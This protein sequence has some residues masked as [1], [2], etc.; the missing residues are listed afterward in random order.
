MPELR[1]DPIGDHWVIL[2]PGRAQRSS[3]F[4]S[5]NAAVRSEE[6]CPFCPGHEAET[7]PEVFAV[8]DAGPPNQPG[9]Q[10]RIFPNK[11]PALEPQGEAPHGGFGFHEVVVDTP[12]HHQTLATA[13]VE[14]TE[15]AFGAIQARMRQLAEDA[16]V[17]YI[18]LFKNHG[19]A[20]GAT[21]EHSHAQLLALPIV[22]PRVLQE[23]ERS[24]SHYAASG[25]CWF[26]ESVSE[27]AAAGRLVFESD[28]FAVLTPYAARFPFEVWLLPKRHESRFELAE[29]RREMAETF[30]GTLSALERALR[31]PAYNAVLVNAPP[32]T[33]AAPHLHWRLEFLPRLG[34]VAG[35]EWGTGCFI[36]PIRPEDAADLLRAAWRV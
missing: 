3:D 35:F 24:R 28:L 31:D 25:R 29:H 6:F 8:R 18:S 17:A 2:A 16:R 20:A 19:A 32:R 22:P 15:A 9:W 36:N 27:A 1:H 23:G 30:A 7:P 14:Q 34:K 11:Y 4:E 5:R 10:V 21:R 12:D 33:A 26:C 13:P